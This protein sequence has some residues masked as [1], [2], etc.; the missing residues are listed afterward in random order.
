MIIRK[1]YF[2]VY[3]E[4]TIITYGA[5]EGRLVETSGNPSAEFDTEKEMLKYISENK[6]EV[7]DE[8]I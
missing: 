3:R 7:K 1:P 5:L 8:I 2:V 4:N 6:L